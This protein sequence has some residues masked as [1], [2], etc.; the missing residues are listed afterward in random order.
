ME[1]EENAIIVMNEK[2]E[3]QRLKRL[4]SPS[5]G[6]RIYYTHEDIVPQRTQIMTV[7]FI[8]KT[9][10]KFISGMAAALVLLIMLV[11]FMQQLLYK[12]Q[13]ITD[14]HLSAITVIALDINP[15]FELWLDEENRV[16]SVIAMNLDARNMKVN[17]N[18]MG[19]SAEDAIEM[20]VEKT[21]DKGFIDG[22]DYEEDYIMLTIAANNKQ[23]E[24]AIRQGIRAKAASSTTLRQL[25]VALLSSDKNALK[26]AED[27]QVP[28]GLYVL[29]VRD[30]TTVKAYMSDESHIEKVEDK[31]D[32][33]YSAPEYQLERLEQGI[34]ELPIEGNDKE[35][36]KGVLANIGEKYKQYRD[37]YEQ[38][39]N[40]YEQ[41]LESNDVSLIKEAEQ[42]LKKAKNEERKM[43]IEAKQLRKT[44]QKIQ[45]HLKGPVGEGKVSEDI[46]DDILKHLQREKQID[47]IKKPSDSFDNSEKR[48]NSDAPEKTDKPSKDDKPN[49]PDKIDKPNKLDNSDKKNSNS[50]RKNNLD[51]RNKEI[52]ENEEKEKDKGNRP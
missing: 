25:S 18:M 7:P 5:I 8:S 12:Q 27:S 9:S 21:K 11:P 34:G 24:A 48:G 32:I 42:A 4:E 39:L 40:A 16:V 10:V 19:L 28:L 51:N 43:R 30:K 36:L 3:F 49:R 50:E 22:E 35:L 20:L 15:S 44:A 26:K 1:I 41:A 52:K 37:T 23:E 13:G 6:A 14:D 38:A 47:T 17:T 46:T 33:I 29:G 31:G 2:G 45:E